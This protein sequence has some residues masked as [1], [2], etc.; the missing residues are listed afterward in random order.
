VSGM[1][2]QM[3]G[4]LGL[5]GWQWLFIIEGVPAAIAGLCLLWFLPER[6][7]EATWLTESERQ[8]VV[9]RIASERRPKEVKHLSLAL[10]D[11][12]VLILAGVQFGFL[13]GSYGTVIFLPQILQKGGLSD[14]QIGFVTSACFAVASLTMILWAN[15]VQ[16]RG[17]KVGNLAIACAT[18][19]VGF[20]GAILLRDQFWLSVLGITLAVSGVNAARALFWTIPPRFLTGLAAAGGLAFINSIGTAGGFVG[21][22]AVGWLTDRTGSFTAGLIAMGG[23]LLLAALLASSLKLLAKGE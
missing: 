9:D 1:L 8:I 14:L 7:E 22:Y 3:D 2:L 19:A 6:P 21:P 11:P 12:R 4:M 15:R 23:F 16:V 17:N 13:V 18:A 5:A 10:R 20:L